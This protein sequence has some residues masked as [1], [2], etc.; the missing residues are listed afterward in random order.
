MKTNLLLF[1]ILILVVIQVTEARKGKLKIGK[2][3]RRLFVGKKHHKHDKAESTSVYSLVY[4]ARSSIISAHLSLLSHV[5]P[6]SIPLPTATTFNGFP[7]L[8]AGSLPKQAEVYI[9][10][11][12]RN[13][14]YFFGY[15]TVLSGVNYFRNPRFMIAGRRPCGCCDNKIIIVTR[16][17]DERI[18]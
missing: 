8:Y 6:T 3:I 10:V 2:K 18:I 14:N 9:T 12:D 15:P 11:T 16:A 5:K 1:L 13:Y 4:S 7:A 17:P